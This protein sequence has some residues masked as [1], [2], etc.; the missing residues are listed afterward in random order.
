MSKTLGGMNDEFALRDL[1]NPNVR[2]KKRRERE[3]ERQ[4]TTVHSLTKL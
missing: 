2:R 3:R 1:E 4:H